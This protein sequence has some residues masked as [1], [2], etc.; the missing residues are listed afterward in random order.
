MRAA[1][2]A[3]VSSSR[4]EQERTIASQLEALEGYAA[5]HGYELASTSRFCDDGFS[6]AR[7]DRPALDALRDGARAGAFEA[8]V[9]LDPDRLARNYAY[10]V[11]IIEELQ[12]FGVS[13]VFLQQ[14]PLDD[15]AARLLV[16]I[17]GAVAE[18]E[19]AKIAER[20]RRGRLFRLRQGEVSIAR[21]PYGYR[22]VPRTPA[23]PAHLVVHEPEAAVVRQIFSWHADEEGTTLYRI[24]ERL[25]DRSIPTPRGAPRWSSQAVRT[26][27]RNSVYT[28]AWVVN[29]TRQAED[30]TSHRKLPRPE[31]EWITVPVPP[32]VGRE[33]FLRSQQRHAH[34]AHYSR[35]HTKEPRWL[36]RGLVR[37]GVCHH[38][39]VTVRTPDGH[40]GRYWNDYYHCRCNNRTSVPRCR[41]PLLRARELDEFVW[42]EVTRTLCNPHLL[43]QAV[44]GGATVAADS[45]LVTSQRTALERQIRAAAHERQRLLDAYQAGVVSLPELEP[46]LAS[47][48]LRSEQWQNEHERLERVQ[49]DAAAAQALL[50]RLD[51]LAHRVRERLTAIDFAQRQALLREVLERVEAT[52]SEVRLYYRI[53]L[54]PTPSTS[55]VST[56]LRLRQDSGGLLPQPEDPQLEIGPVY[57][58]LE[59]RIRAH[60]THAAAS[61][62]RVGAAPA[63]D[64]P[65]RRREPESRR[66]ISPPAAC[67]DGGTSSPREHPEPVLVQRLRSPWGAW[68]GQSPR[69][70]MNQAVRHRRKA[71]AASRTG[72]GSCV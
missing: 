48:R 9:V 56:E 39:C 61:P 8:V 37:C 36:L 20:N 47:L 19:R 4:Q 44:A 23:E 71:S 22:R 72:D 30:P 12:R 40:G 5:S 21:A 50:D 70:A 11:L 26:I 69:G 51:N 64:C 18:Y 31:E 28:G 66:R 29:R 62:P 7:L 3:R 13:V 34:N 1:L 63:P 2:Y 67:S 59:A 54:P 53:P 35:R 27:L 24:A 43:Q 33:T 42:S 15:P 6:G 16:Q 14:P 58:R 17:Q 65:G 38:A 32:L 45:A 52:T 25:Q 60:V 49:Q 55:N 10:Q 57:H 68:S 41:A 46:R